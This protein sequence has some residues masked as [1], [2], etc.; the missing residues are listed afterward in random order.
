MKDKQAGDNLSTDAT[1]LETA[2][3]PERPTIPNPQTPPSLLPPVSNVNMG[4]RVSLANG[5]AARIE[6]WVAKRV[7]SNRG[8][9]QSQGR[10]PGFVSPIKS[11]LM[12]QAAAARRGSIPYPSAFPEGQ[13]MRSPNGS[14]PKISPSVRHMPSALHLAAIRNNSR[15][16]SMPGAAQLIS[17]GPFTPPRFSSE[18]YPV[19]NGNGRPSRD[20]TPIKDQAS[21]HPLQPE[22]VFGETDFTT[23]YLTPPSSTYRPS[24]NTSPTSYLPPDSGST[25]YDYAYD[26]S[27]QNP[28]IPNAPLPNPTFSF[29]SGASQRH[30]ISLDDDYAP[31]MASQ[32]RA[33]IGSMASIN[34]FTTD[35]GTENG[36]DYAQECFAQPFEGFDP[37]AR[38]ASAYVPLQ[39][40]YLVLM[41]VAPPICYIISAS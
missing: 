5:E 13:E 1:A 35:A 19:G 7:A 36:S 26:P 17:S 37:D 4:R 20:L 33:R 18:A 25:T 11:P 12:G 3:T 38:R 32:P 39:S 6:K 24:N 29:G 8:P 40:I 34:T 10:P 41:E 30:S 15:R 9:L 21:T 28:F 23:T 27:Q 22:F 2:K 14:S 16:A 31:F